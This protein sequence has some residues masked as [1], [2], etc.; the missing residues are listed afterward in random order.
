M[1]QLI[2]HYGDHRVLKLCAQHVE[3]STPTKTADIPVKPSDDCRQGSS[4]EGCHSANGR[5]RPLLVMLI[6]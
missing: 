2:V 6:A 3:K 5:N 1:A 4:V